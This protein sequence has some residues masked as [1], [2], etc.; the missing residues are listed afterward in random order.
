M[1]LRAFST[2]EYDSLIASLLLSVVGACTML[3]SNGIAMGFSS[4]TLSDIGKYPF[5][6]LLILFSIPI[7][8]A[9]C[10][11]LEYTSA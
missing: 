5:I 11:P 8:L 4:M 7:P 1:C 10:F 6:D 9:C 2:Y 3:T